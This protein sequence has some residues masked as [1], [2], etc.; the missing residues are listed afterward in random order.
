M[1][2]A[3]HSDHGKQRGRNEEDPSPRKD[4]RERGGDNERAEDVTAGEGLPFRLLGKQRFDLQLFIG[5]RTVDQ[6]SDY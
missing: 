3:E 4:E 2:A 5:A 1:H 6:Q